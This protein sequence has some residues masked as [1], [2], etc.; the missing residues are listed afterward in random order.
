MELNKGR[1]PG[2]PRKLPLV[3]SK[4]A[5]FSQ[6]WPTRWPRKSPFASPTEMMWRCSFLKEERIALSCFAFDEKLRTKLQL[7]SECGVRKKCPS[8]GRNERVICY[9][10]GVFIL[11]QLVFDLT[12]SLSEIFQCS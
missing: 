10:V 4:R 11:L 9:I 5:F 2:D 3:T 8:S 7:V 1:G 6:I 12:V